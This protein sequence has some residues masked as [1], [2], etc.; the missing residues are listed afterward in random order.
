M[1]KYVI[2]E[3]SDFHGGSSG[4]ARMYHIEKFKD[5]ESDILW[6]HPSRIVDEGS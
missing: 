4:P 5:G 1:G 6:L 3:I 2:L